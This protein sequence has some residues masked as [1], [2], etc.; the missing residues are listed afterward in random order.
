MTYGAHYATMHDAARCFSS[1]EV[2]RWLSEHDALETLEGDALQCACGWASGYRREPM[3]TEEL[4]HVRV[5]ERSNA[6][7][8]KRKKECFLL[9]AFVGSVLVGDGSEKLLQRCE[10]DEKP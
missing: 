9:G 7:F 1:N 8:A 10:A 3:S 4:L 2:G 5:L 6:V